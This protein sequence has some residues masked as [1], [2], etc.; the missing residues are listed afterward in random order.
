[1]DNLV[2]QNLPEG[3]N[4]LI[5]SGAQMLQVRTQ[6]QTMVAVQ[7]PRDLEKIRKTLLEEAGP[8]FYYSIPYKNH[9]KNCR[10]RRN[11]KCPE[12]FVEGG[13]VR[14][15]RSAAREWGNCSVH[16]A[17]QQTTPTSWII[18]ATFIDF[19]T[20]YTNTDIYEQPRLIPTKQGNWINPDPQRA[21]MLFQTGCAFAERNAILKALPSAMI[22]GVIDKAKKRAVDKEKPL[23]ERIKN[24]VSKFAKL[25][26]SER[27]LETSLDHDINETTTDELAELIGLYNAIKDGQLKVE[28]AFAEEN[29]DTANA[30][31]E[32]AEDIKTSDVELG[33]PLEQKDMG[34]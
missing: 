22:K 6:F 26:V 25:G 16:K 12:V 21:R 7:R 19:E 28:E 18:E 11:C 29:V 14:L 33:K 3:V 4:D 5:S 10:D 1:M 17:V 13:S 24:M 23:P 20:N 31:S 8:D 30:S 2:K 15:A 27:M 9:V 32:S 34:F